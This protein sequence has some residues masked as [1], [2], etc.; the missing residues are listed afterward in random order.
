[1][2]ACNFSFSITDCFWFFSWYVFNY[3]ILGS[4]YF[5]PLPFLA[6]RMAWMVSFFYDTQFKGNAL[7][8]DDL[9]IKQ[10]IG[11]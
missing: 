7:M 1:M 4:L 3:N 6:S 11:R 2:I 10:F 5:F 9:T 8:G